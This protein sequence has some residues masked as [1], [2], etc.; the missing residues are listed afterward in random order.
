MGK[1]KKHK[2]NSALKAIRPFAEDVRLFLD[3]LIERNFA[4]DSLASY[5]GALKDFMAFLSGRNVA[6]LADVT[7]SDLETYRTSLVDR[8]LS[9]RT[10]EIYLRRVRRFFGWLEDTQRVFCNPAA[11]LSLPRPPQDLQPIPTEAEMR[12]L[13]AVP[14]V[15]KA[16]GIRDRAL[17]ETTYSTGLRR[18]EVVRLKLTDPDLDRGLVRVMGKGRKERTVPLGKIALHWLR[19]YIREARPKLLNGEPDVAALWVARGSTSLGIVRI[20]QMFRQYADAAGIRAARSPHAVRRACATHM[21]AHGAHPV[22]IQMLLG[23]TDLKHLGKYLR[24]TIRDL[25]QSH[26]Q[27]QPG[28]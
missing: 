15:S 14:D 18:G 6:R 23:H 16:T 22:Q 26:R 19:Q 4:D 1:W 13:L 5:W 12:K 11:L 3:E 28:R 7:E 20:Q 25:K 21:L 27:T 2:C 8:R 17:L 9:P 10:V 24:V